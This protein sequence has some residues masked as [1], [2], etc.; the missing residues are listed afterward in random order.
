MQPAFILQQEF[1]LFKNTDP[2]EKHQKAIPISVISKLIHQDSTKLEQAIGNLATVGIFFAMHSCEDLKVAKPK[3]QRTKMLGLRNVRFFQGV[4]QLDYNHREL[5]FADC[6]AITF[7]QQNKDKKMDTVTFMASQDA[8]LC[9]VRAA[10]A[11]VRRIRQY[12]GSSQD[13][14]ILTVT[15]NGHL[16]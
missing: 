6:V 1:S 14:P 11:I 7:K 13:S 15:V 16:E 4:E 5:E 3:Q 9:L 12:P 10:A 2:E 8:C